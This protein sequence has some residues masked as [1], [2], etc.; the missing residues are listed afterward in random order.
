MKKLFIL[1]LII[2]STLSF[3][4]FHDK[5]NELLKP[6]LS[7]YIESKI[8]QNI[9]LEITHLKLDINHLELEAL[10]NESTKVHTQGAFSLIDQTVDLNYKLNSDGFKNEQISFDNK[11]DI[12]GTLQGSLKNLNIKGEGESLKSH[13]DY[14][15][16]IKEKQINNIKVKM[17]KA[18]IASL[19]QL[20][21]EPIYAQGKVDINID[22]PTF[23]EANTNGD[24]K[25]ILHKTLLN[26]KVFKEVLD[27]DLP[28]KTIVTAKLNAKVISKNVQI[29]GDVKSNLAWLKLSN[30]NY[31]LKSKELSS[32][33][34]AF[35]P[36]LSKLAF[37]TKQQLRG[38]LQVN[39][40]LD[41]KNKNLIVTGSS[42]DLGG[43]TSFDYHGQ[44]LTANMNQ[45]EISKLLYL[46][47]QPSYAT[48][49]LLA[50]F[51]IDDFKKLRGSYE[52]ESKDA[53]TIHA[54]LKEYL[55]LDFGEAMAFSLKSKGDIASNLANIE[56]SLYSD[57]FQYRSS[58]MVYNLATK[59]LNSTYLLDIPNLSKLNALAG[60]NLN[61]EVNI[62][63]AINYDTT[64]KVTGNSKSLGGNIDFTLIDKILSSKIDNVSVEKLMTVL[65]Y[66][67][68]FKATILGDFYYDLAS[69]QGTLIS[70]LNQAQLIP[71]NLTK[72]IK[73]VQGVD[74]TKER[75]NETHFK[76]I[77]NKNIIDIDFQAKSKKALFAIPSGKINKANNSINA[78]YKIDIDNKDIEGSLKGNI[79]NP[80]ITLDS[81][82]FIQDKVINVI[83]E[84]VN[85][86]TLKDF[87]IGQQETEAIK[88]LLSDLFK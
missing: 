18:D 81:S 23:E 62:N 38:Q 39:G 22:I 16:N 42:K 47:N 59:K 34:K 41:L 64:L 10:L 67:L 20:A 68:V 37:L 43:E 72:L 80:K 55:N 7:K 36:E 1:L 14:A 17:N 12:N 60:K 13:I 75:Y 65:S 44:K 31:H 40:K 27:I 48:G 28:P 77:L 63:G 79:N 15:L 4:I 71:N 86:E 32:D 85:E 24:A 58:D 3:F 19:L 82:N 66:P 5:G 61:G 11:I 56:S 26:Q 88:N 84:N 21:S 76:A 9:S 78:K 54:T 8:E 6:H 50:R 45:I 87:G 30:S 73:Q 53:K 49:T 35:I 29:S 2:I 25:I 46:L 70:T 52:L 57:I 69:R 83:K 74:L 51:K 33:Y